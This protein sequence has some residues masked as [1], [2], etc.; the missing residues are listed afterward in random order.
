MISDKDRAILGYLQNIELELHDQEKGQGYDLIFRFEPNSYFEGTEIKK[1]FHMKHKGMADSTKSTE[2]KWKDNCDPTIMKKKKKKKGKKVNVTVKCRSFFNFFKDRDPNS[3]GDDDD[4]DEEEDDDMDDQQ[5][6]GDQI[7]DDLVPLALEYYLG[8][9]DIDDEDDSDDDSDGKK[10]DG[11]DDDEDGAKKKKKKSKKGGP[12][13]P[14]G[15]D[16]KECK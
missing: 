5:E 13:L 3:T 8:V 11:S 2:I 14:E 4:N 15:A 1:E 6:I 16:P 12:K 10:D 7:K 9:I